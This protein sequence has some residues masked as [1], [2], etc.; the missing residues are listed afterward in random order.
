[1]YPRAIMSLSTSMQ[2]HSS[3][4]CFLHKFSAKEREGEAPYFCL[5]TGQLIHC[6]IS[7]PPEKLSSQVLW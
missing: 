3:K 7:F 4:D 2:L 5:P 1:M 6:E